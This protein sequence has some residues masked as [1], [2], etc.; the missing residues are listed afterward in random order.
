MQRKRAHPTA[1]D[2]VYN[3]TVE[4]S[5]GAQAD[6]KLVN[7]NPPYVDPVL[8]DEDGFEMAVGAPHARTFNGVYIFDVDD[9]TY[10]VKVF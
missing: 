2:V 4:F 10:I 6:I 1:P 9:N 7:A 3:K 5:D 8:F